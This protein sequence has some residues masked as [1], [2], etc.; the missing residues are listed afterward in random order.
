[1][2]I[3]DVFAFDDFSVAKFKERDEKALNAFATRF[4]FLWWSKGARTD[5][6][7]NMTSQNEEDLEDLLGREATASNE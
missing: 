2:V 1:L 4:F 3:L 5:N 7:R 6:K